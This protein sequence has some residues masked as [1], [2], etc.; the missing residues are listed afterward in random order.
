MKISLL[1]LAA[2]VT[3]IPVAVMSLFIAIGGEDAEKAAAGSF[4]SAAGIVAEQATADIVRACEV[5]RKTD[6]LF[7]AEAKKAFIDRLGK[8]GKVTVSNAV[9][10][11][12]VREQ[13]APDS[14]MKKVGVRLL[15]FGGE[16][17]DFRFGKPENERIERM[18]ESLKSEFACEF[19]I[20]AFLP[21]ER[22]LLRVATTIKN[23]EVGIMCGTMMSAGRSRGAASIIS[24]LERGMDFSGIVDVGDNSLAATYIPLENGAGEL[25]GALFFGKKSDTV[26][27]LESWL[28]TLKV[29]GSGSAWVIDNS[30]PAIPRIRIARD[31]SLVGMVVSNDTV[32]ARRNFLVSALSSYAEMKSGAI[33]SEKFSAPFGGGDRI[34]CYSRYEPWGWII[35]T[36]CN[37]A[38]F[39]EAGAFLEESANSFLLRIILIGL[40]S[41]AVGLSLAYVLSAAMTRPL[42]LLTRISIAQAAGRLGEAGELSKKLETAVPI[43][44]FAILSESMR[45]MVLA[46][47]DVVGEVVG[48]ALGLSRR[49]SK[50]SNAAIEMGAAASSEE[51]AIERASGAGRLVS[52][53]GEAVARAAAEAGENAD[54]IVSLCSGGG[55]KLSSLMKN[56]DAVFSASE[57]FGERLEKISASVDDIS[58]I[59]AR[60]NETGVKMNLLSMN[61]SLEAEKSGDIG[62]A[63]AVASKHVRNLASEATELARETE[64][65]ARRLRKSAEDGLARVDEIAVRMRGGSN[66][67]VG[68]APVLSDAMGLAEKMAVGFKGI[69]S[70]VEELSDS[71]KLVGRKLDEMSAESSRSRRGISLFSEQTQYLV[72]TGEMLL[73]EASHFD[74]SG[75]RAKGGAG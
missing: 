17:A 65:V 6:G 47:S 46:L 12:L 32:G 9:S 68:A 75:L 51:M 41:S 5:V 28:K 55:E 36:V 59:V 44:E 11:R 38:E 25:V 20:L 1:G 18:L 67:I 3:V 53:S 21:A 10:D 71:A 49:A 27:R 60:I 72:S 66:A 40:L 13:G 15:S 62:A 14:E 2:V 63:F 69:S 35:G 70:A 33:R 50:L 73:S 26:R 4:A 58:G 45:R 31:D 24:N 19:G 54:S 8:L 23:P 74:V 29:G 34:V 7:G 56:Y 43:A 64:G 48:T 61:A 39:A 52:A 37:P 22:A 16:T 30:C 57:N 42:K